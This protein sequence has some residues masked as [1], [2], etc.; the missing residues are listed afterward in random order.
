MS[1]NMRKTGILI[2][3]FLVF[4]AGT[5]LI[6]QSR[7]RKGE[8][9]PDY[10]TLKADPLGSLALFESLQKTPGLTVTRNYSSTSIADISNSTIFFIGIQPFIFEMEGSPVS[11]I[12]SLLKKGNR[13]IVSFL[14]PPLF[15][16]SST[17][18][19]STGKSNV[20]FTRSIKFKSKNSDTAC[21]RS[22]DSLFKA[23]TWPGALNL[24]ADST[25]K[26]IVSRDSFMLLGE[27]KVHTGVLVVLHDGYNLS[28]QGLRDNL[29]RSGSNPLIPYL[30]GNT[31]NI[32]FDESHHGIVKRMGISVLLQKTG[33]TPVI[34][35]L[36]IWF[37]LLIWYIQGI[38]AKIQPSSMNY[39]QQHDT[40]DSLQLILTS[41][42]SPKK[43]VQICRDEW[44]KS[45]PALQ[46]PDPEGKTNV[47]QYNSQI[48]N[49][50]Q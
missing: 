25:W 46:L 21:V 28:N 2:F 26:T 31:A 49:K 11:S 38:T 39:S 4:F 17:L 8:T 35:F 23:V 44:R 30:T 22:S 50:R 48:K 37:F 45:F 36:C 40:P 16:P 12:D 6:F 29:T 10:S 32:I 3:T 19:D 7:F 47:E 33:F 41:R 13:V 15:A 1:D 43:I 5:I 20:L 24:Q 34:V 42:I 9:F 14:D 27:K 18:P